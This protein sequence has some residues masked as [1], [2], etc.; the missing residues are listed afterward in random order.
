ML[1]LDGTETFPAPRPERGR[2]AEERSVSAQRPARL[3]ALAAVLL[4]CLCACT[5]LRVSQRVADPSVRL[6]S[7]ASFRFRPPPLDADARVP[8][9]TRALDHAV[10]AA[11]AATLD[12]AGY[13]PAAA[14]DSDSLTLDYVI[15]QGGGANAR[16]LDSPSD[17]ARSWRPDRPQ[18]GTGSMDHMVADVAFYRELT[19]TVLLFPPGSGTLAWEGTASRSFPAALPEGGALQRAV[20]RMIQRLLAPLPRR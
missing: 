3:R 12:A 16:R 7:F 10:R 4:I 11:I 14:G 6:E 2:R 19:L 15:A 9:P 17:Y 1:F 18:D 13:R 20:D 8:A 5:D